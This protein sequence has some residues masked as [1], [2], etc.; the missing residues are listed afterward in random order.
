MIDV[1]RMRV[2]VPVSILLAYMFLQCMFVSIVCFPDLTIIDE[3]VII[4]RRVGATITVQLGF[5]DEA[6]N[7]YLLP[8]TLV[9]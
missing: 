4:D 7:H 6:G 5:A 9:Y 2:V 3:R 1:M 8:S